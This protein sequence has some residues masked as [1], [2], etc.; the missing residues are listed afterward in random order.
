MIYPTL[1]ID[2]FFNDPDE[3]RNIGFSLDKEEINNA[4]PGER[5]KPL[6]IVN[7]SFFN[8]STNK[9][10]SAVFNHQPEDLKLTF[11]AYQSFQFIKS[12]P[13]E[14][15]G[16][17][18]NDN[19]YEFTAMVYLSKHKNCGTSLYKRK[20]GSF[21][22][23]RDSHINNNNIKKIY[24][25]SNKKYDEKYFKARDEQNEGFERTV[26]V[27]SLYN[28]LLIFDS[29]QYHGVENFYDPKIKEDRMTLITFF[30]NIH[31]AKRL[32]IPN[33]RRYL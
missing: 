5:S 13:K 6:H 8:W 21:P 20:E 32:P 1:I 9:I 29:F 23:Q 16:W 2:N 12:N 7:P 26:K 28:R 30:N 24:Y 25:G 33:T 31:G 18:H 4:Y 22:F 15:H 3:V 11:D 10:L 14:G 19:D 27:E 17:V